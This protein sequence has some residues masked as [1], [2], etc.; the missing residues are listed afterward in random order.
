[1]VDLA[2]MY[3][4]LKETANGGDPEALRMAGEAFLDS[5]G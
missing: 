5:L 3:E 4:L 1:M 2:A